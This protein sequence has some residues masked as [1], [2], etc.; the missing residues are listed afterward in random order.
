[1]AVLKKVHLFQTITIFYKAVNV[2]LLRESMKV[3]STLVQENNHLKY[4]IFSIDLRFSKRS[5]DWH[6]K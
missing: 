6:N 3:M 5:G 2:Y 1:M 4:I